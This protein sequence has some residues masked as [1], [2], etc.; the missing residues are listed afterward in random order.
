M[1]ALHVHLGLLQSGSGWGM[2][3]RLVMC[4][5]PPQPNGQTDRH[6]GQLSQERPSSALTFPH[7]S[8][9]LYHG[10]GQDEGLGSDLHSCPSPATF[11][12]VN[13]VD[14]CSLSLTQK[15]PICVDL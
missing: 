7:A 3:D 15:D 5:T 13:L 2:T 1:P 9:L 4:V 12:Y 8:L 6:H 11:S 10:K 14:S